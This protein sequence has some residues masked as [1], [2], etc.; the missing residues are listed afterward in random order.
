M[1]TFYFTRALLFFVLFFILSCGEGGFRVSNL[2]EIEPSSSGMPKDPELL[3]PEEG[4]PHSPTGESD[5]A[6]RQV[7]ITV[8]SSELQGNYLSK[9]SL[10]QRA[11]LINFPT[12]ILLDDVEIIYQGFGPCLRVYSLN[13]AS[14]SDMGVNPNTGD[15]PSP[16]PP[17]PPPFPQPSPVMPPP[18]N[19]SC[20][21]PGPHVSVVDT[22]VLNQGFNRST[23]FPSPSQIIAFK[24]T[25]P[26]GGEITSD[27]AATKTSSARVT[28]L[29]SVSECP[30]D[31]TNPVAGNLRGC[32]K[33]SV[34]SSRIYL[35]SISTA[36]ER[37][38][39]ILEP[40]KTYYI[41]A[42]SVE[43]V[44]SQ[45]ATCSDSRTCSFYASRMAQ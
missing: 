42:V 14:G 1:S 27:F 22:G 38:Y 30:G 41:N 15:Q 3:F 37:A 7:E 13:G 25:V 10:V 20:G 45:T 21:V 32:L 44:D 4:G 24:V 31:Y 2:A 26:V 5:S 40:G 35:T 23:Y 28:K 19:T 8:D 33:F 43:R 9:E 36:P 11:T 6:L 29:V 16:L 12:C 17:P 39:C 18:S 34:E